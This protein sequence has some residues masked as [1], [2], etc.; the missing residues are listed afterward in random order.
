MECRNRS[1]CAVIRA[2][3][4][5]AACLL[6]TAG[7]KL[8]K[9]PLIALLPAE[10]AV[11]K[12]RTIDGIDLAKES[13]SVPEQLSDAANDSKDS[14]KSDAEELPTPDTTN[15]APTGRL[16]TNDSQAD[17]L[18][19][20]PAERVILSL[21]DA[22]TS[23]LDAN[24]ELRVEQV[25]PAIARQ[26]VSQEA[27]R[28][29]ATFNSSYVRNRVDPPPGVLA[30]GPPDTTFDIFSNS[31]TQPLIAGGAVTALHDFTKT[32][33]HGSNAFNSVDT[34]LGVEYRQ[35][36][37]RGFGYKINTASIQIARAQTGIADARS[38]L[39]AIRVL[40]DVERAYWQLYAAHKFH[41]IALQQ[42]DLARRQYTG[43]KRLFDAGVFT[44]VDA[45]VAESGVLVREDAAIQTETAVR[46]AQREL[47]RIM[48]R[49]DAP[50]GGPTEI[51]LATE[52]NPL[53]LEF[54][55]ENLALRGI[56]NRMEML[57][58]QLRLLADSIDQQVQRN[59]ILPR[60]DLTAEIDALGLESSYRKSMDVLLENDFGDRLVG[61]AL[62][63]PLSG[64]VSARSVCAKCSCG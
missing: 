47:K 28:F 56:E 40:A 21:A 12:L 64:N 50:V 26:I 14:P 6:S 41:E 62:E 30:G 36:L 17:E 15:R 5:I 44:N 63:V 39:T 9:F 25:N 8:P 32:D 4:L 34:D 43:V 18:P 54:D 51:V 23:A 58:L 31:I 10:E 55:R 1:W 2:C 20:P 52:P 46:V 61:I 60:L 27:G 33:I 35:P 49:L 38:K 29:E 48:Q 53:G 16:S 3:A 57:E 11:S 22:R 7:C 42:L 59:S 13:T 24:L 37:L 19:V 45:L